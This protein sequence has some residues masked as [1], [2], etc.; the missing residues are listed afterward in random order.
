MLIVNGTKDPVGGGANP[1]GT[2]SSLLYFRIIPLTLKHYFMD[3]VFARIMHALGLLVFSSRTGSLVFAP[4]PGGDP[5]LL[6]EECRRLHSV[7][8]SVRLQHPGLCGRCCLRA[9]VAVGIVSKR[10]AEGLTPPVR[11]GRES[12]ER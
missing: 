4:S 8:R 10:R 3:I 12:V 9:S 2:T 1:W 6:G 7:C 5:H 11:T